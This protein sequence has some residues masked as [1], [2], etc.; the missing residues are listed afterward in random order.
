MEH[1]FLVI[2]PN[3]GIVTG[4]VFAAIW[5]CG[6]HAPYLSIFISR[7]TLGV[8]PLNCV[9]VM[10]R[11]LPNNYTRS[12]LLNLLEKQGFVGRF[13][14]LC[15]GNSMENSMESSM[16]SGQSFD[17]KVGVESVE[18]DL[19]WLFEVFWMQCV[20]VIW[21]NLLPDT[22]VSCCGKPPGIYHAT[23]SEKRTLV[24]PIVCSW[25]F[26]MTWEWSI[27]DC[28]SV[29]ILYMISVYIC[30]AALFDTLY[31]LLGI[32]AMHSWTLSIVRSGDHHAHFFHHGKA[33]LRQSTKR[34]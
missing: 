13:D 19:F 20:E 6:M 14:F 3:V 8:D 24:A 15:L 28:I 12:M 22:A 32:W 7:D 18:F 9:E 25:Y 30:K 34:S 10:L 4:Q 5:V 23:S 16:E 17:R 27:V 29:Y 26:A 11:N 2:A 1:H 33:S 31:L 21:F